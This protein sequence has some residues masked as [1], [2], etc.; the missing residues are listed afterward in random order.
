[1]ISVMNEHKIDMKK[2]LFQ[3]NS[4]KVP[5]LQTLSKMVAY[6]KRY[7]YTVV[8]GVMKYIQPKAVFA[9]K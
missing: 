2:K 5:N 7:Q 3:T 1:M 6:H 8:L 9:S 4:F